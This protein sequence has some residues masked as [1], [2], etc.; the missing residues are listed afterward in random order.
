LFARGNQNIV[1]LLI[2]QVRDQ[3]VRAQRGYGRL[4]GGEDQGGRLRAIH[5]A[6]EA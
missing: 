3:Q 4:H 5:F 6:E 2:K 1:L